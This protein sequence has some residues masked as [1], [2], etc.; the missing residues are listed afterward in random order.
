MSSRCAGGHEIPTIRAKVGM[1]AVDDIAKHVEGFYVDGKRGYAGFF[2]T[3]R[4]DNF[5][6]VM[7]EIIGRR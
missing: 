3:D 1:V 5:I 4:A 2:V 7:V 6:R